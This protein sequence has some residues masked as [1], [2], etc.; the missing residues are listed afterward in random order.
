M[1]KSKPKKPSAVIKD[2]VAAIRE[3]HKRLHPDDRCLWCG[4]K[5][6]DCECD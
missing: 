3:R 4:K 6:R 1:I 5:F 2:E